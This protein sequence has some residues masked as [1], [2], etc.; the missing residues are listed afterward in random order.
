MESKRSKIWHALLTAFFAAFLITIGGWVGQNIQYLLSSITRTQSWWIGLLA[1]IITTAIFTLLV[2]AL[3]GYIW[4]RS[5]SPMVLRWMIFGL[6]AG[7]ML[8]MW[9]DSKHGGKSKNPFAALD[10]ETINR[11]VKQASD[12]VIDDMKAK[13]KAIEKQEIDP[14]KSSL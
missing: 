9:A 5:M 8:G 13:Q 6:F 1:I 12:Q 2:L 14:S 4:L 3:L 11:I 7:M 10:Q